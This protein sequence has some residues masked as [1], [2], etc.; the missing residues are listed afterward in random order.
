MR[1]IRYGTLNKLVEHLCSDTGEID[2][3]YI[4]IFLATYRSFASPKQ[5]LNLLF[6]RSVLVHYR[7]FAS[8]KQVLYLGFVWSVFVTYRSFCGFS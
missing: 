7:S 1:V 6:A 3:T 2:S 8:P 5:V 4:N